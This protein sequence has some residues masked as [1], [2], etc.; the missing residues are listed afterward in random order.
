MFLKH[1]V[2]DSDHDSRSV[3][4]KQ[5]AGLRACDYGKC[6]AQA[7]GPGIQEVLVNFELCPKHH[8]LHVAWQLT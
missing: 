7:R 8:Q 3:K 1:A 4:G 5:Q 6:E 2:N